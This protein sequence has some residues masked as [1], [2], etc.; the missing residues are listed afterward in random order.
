MTYVCLILIMLASFVGFAATLAGFSGTLIVWAGVF[1]CAVLGGFGT[2]SPVMLLVL[3]LLAAAG[4]A[5]EYM[6]GILGARKFGATKKGM[7]GALVGGIIGAFVLTF[8]LP[9]IG[10]AVGVFAGTFAGAFAGEYLSGAGISSSSKAGF[11]AL[12]GRIFAVA[13]K[14]IIMLV[15]AG[16]PF[17]RLIRTL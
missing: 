7:I 6:S 4:E 12:L 3:L 10:T 11:G 14:V 5:L 15:I 1:V 13:V 8:V 17:I 9:V 2:L 16:V